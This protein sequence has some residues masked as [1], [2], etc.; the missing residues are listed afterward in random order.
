M[1]TEN[2]VTYN[3]RMSPRMRRKLNAI[4]RQRD[5]TVREFIHDSLQTLTG[6]DDSDFFRK[7]YELA[8]ELFPDPAAST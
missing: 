1:P 2:S 8:D 7:A 5:K 4:A 6:V 3:L